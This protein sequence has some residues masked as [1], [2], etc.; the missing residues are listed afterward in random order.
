MKLFLM[1][2]DPYNHK[3]CT[4]T[5]DMACF[6]NVEMAFAILPKNAKRSE[7]QFN[8]RQ[9]CSRSSKHIH[10]YC[11]EPGVKID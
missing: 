2:L 11:L 8:L 5:G 4:C 9:M 6:F 10:G 1:K 7:N 3:I